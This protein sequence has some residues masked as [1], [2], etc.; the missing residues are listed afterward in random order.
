MGR[1]VNYNKHRLGGAV[2]WRK[3]CQ[4]I[5]SECLRSSPSQLEWLS[6]D[7]FRKEHRKIN[8]TPKPFQSVQLHLVD[9]SVSELLVEAEI[10]GSAAT[11]EME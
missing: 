4:R 2:F 3:Y 6:Y 5:V 11:V 9:K 8:R 1:H 10:V 7:F